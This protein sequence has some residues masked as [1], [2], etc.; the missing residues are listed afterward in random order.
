MKPLFTGFYCPN[1][2]DKQTVQI[3]EFNGIR[4]GSVVSTVYRTDMFKNIVM[5]VRKICKDFT[6]ECEYEINGIYKTVFYKLTDL[7]PVI[8]YDS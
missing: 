2:C 8:L 6:A 1:N 5:I 4:V 3:V 7:C